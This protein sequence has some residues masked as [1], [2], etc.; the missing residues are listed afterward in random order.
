MELDSLAA[1]LQDQF[2]ASVALS[3]GEGGIALSIALHDTNSL[4]LLCKFLFWDAGC[5]FGGVT[6][7]EHLG[8][9]RLSYV[10]LAPGSGWIEVIVQQPPETLS[11][12]SI[13]SA[14]HAADWHEREAE[15][16]FGLIF[17][18][19]PRLGDFILH[20]QIWPEGVAPH[21]KSVDVH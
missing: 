15:D 1:A 16:L 3:R 9:W 5:P 12:P 2:R 4:P 17:E 20:D 21:R 13:S 8:N 14:V 6:V 11:I 18:G 7:E 10:F 19:H